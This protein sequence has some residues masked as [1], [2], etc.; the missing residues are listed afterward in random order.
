VAGIGLLA[1]ALVSDQIDIAC[2][3]PGSREPRKPCENT[4]IEVGGNSY[5][6]GH[7]QER[8]Q[9]ILF[10][11]QYLKTLPK[12]VKTKSISRSNFE[13]VQPDELPHRL[14]IQKDFL[15]NAIVIVG[16]SFEGS[17]DLEASPLQS[18]MPGVMVHA[19]AIKAFLSDHL[20]FERTTQDWT[21]EVL[22]L[23]YAAGTG[24]LFHVLSTSLSARIVPASQKVNATNSMAVASPIHKGAVSWAPLFEVG[25]EIVVSLVGAICTIGGVFLFS[26]FWA[27]DDLSKSGTIIAVVTPALA[28]GL[29][30]LSEFLHNIKI[31][32]NR[33]ASVVR[34]I[35]L[36]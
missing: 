26:M 28:V 24:A 18:K 34:E 1:A 27:F 16:G 23:L 9:R 19:N 30:G 10:T 15:N 8:E 20:I 35:F 36:T 22:L 14:E 13:T 32:F 21:A 3:F 25:T 5:A 29:E 2:V 11:L 31:L 17:D 33:C 12:G 7:L 6:L 4:K